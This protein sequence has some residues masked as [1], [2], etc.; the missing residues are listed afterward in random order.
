[1]IQNVKIPS[2]SIEFDVKS[3]LNVNNDEHMKNIIDN[4]RNHEQLNC[5][6]KHIWE[7]VGE[8]EFHSPGLE[9]YL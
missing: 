2:I 5:P 7:E 4:Q 1:M 9:K 8:Q 6:V 3:I